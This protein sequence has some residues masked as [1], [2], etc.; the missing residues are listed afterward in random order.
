[1]G[2]NIYSHESIC[3]LRNFL[4]GLQGCEKYKGHNIN[5]AVCI[6]GPTKY[7]HTLVAVNEPGSRGILF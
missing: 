7:E 6:I 2:R 3:M 1:M 5:T 4:A